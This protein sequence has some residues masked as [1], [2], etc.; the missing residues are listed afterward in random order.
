MPQCRHS[1]Q[2]D[3]TTGICKLI[4][5]PDHSDLGQWTCRFTINNDDTD[6]EIG[7]AT[8]VLLNTLAGLCQH[9][10]FRNLLLSFLIHIKLLY[11][12]FSY[13]LYILLVNTRDN[14]SHILYYVQMR[15]WDGSWG[16]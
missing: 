16:H 2:M 5:K 13:I 9:F 4:F 11:I 3:Y 14:F 12:S 8:L 10:F 7:S 1:V 15:N 6:I